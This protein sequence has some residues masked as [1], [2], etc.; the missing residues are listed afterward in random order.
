[1]ELEATKRQATGKSSRRLRREGRL[2]AIVYGNRVTTTPVDVDA[3]QFER[4]LARA[5]R[6]HLIDLVVDNGRPRKVLVKEVQLSPRRRE[7]LHVDFHQVS[8][9]ERLQVEVPITFVGEAEPVRMGLADVLP[10]LHALRVECVPT[11]IPDAIEID[12]SGMSQVEDVLRVADVEL[13]DGVTA[14]A[15]PEDA[16]VKLAARRVIEE[17]AEEVAERAEAGA[18]EPA[19]S[20]EEGEG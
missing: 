6:T 12:V 20:K 9:R 11:R 1:M 16:V 19:E 5:G 2:P 4:V 10:V 17:V 13:P 8:L 18:E 3:R 7:L 15:D 14:V